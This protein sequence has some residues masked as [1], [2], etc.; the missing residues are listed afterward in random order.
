M[1]NL[2]YQQIDLLSKEK[3]IE[4]EIVVSAVEDAVLVATRKYYKST[5]DL[6]S[7]F[8]KETG[9][10]EV[11]AVKQVVE[12]VTN[13]SREISLSEA[14]TIDP[15]AEIDG[16]V[17]IQKPT[18]VLGRIAAQTAKQVILQKVREAERESIFTEYSARIGEVV[19]CLVKRTEGSEVIVELGTAEGRLPRREQ[20][21]LESF[22]MGDRIRVVIIKAEK[23]SKGP[24]VLVS[25][26]DPALLAKLFEMEVPEI[27]DG[28]VTI[29]AAAR[30]TGERSKVAVASRDNDVD[31]VGACVGMKGSRVQGVIRELNGEKIDIIPFSEDP[32]TFVM[33]ALRP[34]KIDRASVLDTE[35]KHLEVIVDT[36]QLSLAIGKKGQNVRLAAKLTGWKIDIKSDEE[37]RAEIEDQMA[38]L[39]AKT[40]LSE[41]PSLSE[42]IMAK[43]SENGIKTIEE[44]A[45]TAIG[46]L[47]NINGVGPKSAE[48]II[49]SVKDYYIQYAEAVESRRDAEAQKRLEE[50]KVAQAKVLG[51]SPETLLP[52]GEA[53]SPEEPIGQ[54]PLDPEVLS[55][56]EL[57]GT[58]SSPGEE[59]MSARLEE[60]KVAQAKVLGTSPET[61]LP[62][63]E[64][65]SPEEPI[66]QKPLDPEVLSAEELVG[67]KSSPGEEEMSA[68]END[69]AENEEIKEE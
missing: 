16:T 27:Y 42:G 64:A 6:T 62:K 59:E 14:Q 66:G 23:T 35:R 17:R 48:K 11:Y 22:A 58:K 34:A 19:T 4:V 30:D 7:S 10:V 49:A 41:L 54:K 57:V 5:E 8:N 39:S 9:Q 43:L 36:D 21:R 24:Q 63:G 50:E 12:T 28:T 3:G 65:E 18:D 31:P 44:L 47:T 45:D 61:L 37:K 15:T 26:I 53:E 56:E 29:R 2:L 1:S 33:N 32:L 40:P 55:A 68:R 52:K 13:S 51:T 25:R 38:L 67:T 46:E 60:E 69:F 20:S